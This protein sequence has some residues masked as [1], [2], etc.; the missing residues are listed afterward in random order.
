MSMDVEVEELVSLRLEAG[1]RGAI[2]R[3][4]W[5]GPG[6]ASR[7]RLGGRRRFLILR[8]VLACD[9]RHGK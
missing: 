5:G 3:V 1:G 7:L 8:R 4:R 6:H 9:Q 2:E